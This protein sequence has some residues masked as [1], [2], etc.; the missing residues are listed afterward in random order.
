MKY[1]LFL[2]VLFFAVAV[3]SAQDFSGYRAGNFTGVNG[4]FFNPASIADSRYR[5]DLNLISAS[6]SVGNNKASFNL[7]DVIKSF[8]ADSLKQQVTGRNA[9]PSNGLISV[10]IH[11]PSF[12]FNAG[13]KMAFA[14]TSR[15]RA[16][17]NITD[18]DGKLADKLMTDFDNNDPALPYTIASNNNMRVNVHAWSEF[19][20]TVARVIKDNGPHFFKTGITF[21]YLAGAGNAYVNAA[22]IRGTLNENRAGDPYLINASGRLSLGFG[23]INLSDDVE[24]SELTKMVTTGFGA[25]IGFVYEY[26]PAREN[27]KVGE[28]DMLRRDANK[29]KFKVG[30]ALLDIGSLKYKRDVQRSGSYTVDVSGADTLQLREL[31]DVELNDY[32]AF[33][34]SRPQYFTP[35]NHNNAGTYNVALPATL[36]INIDYHLHRGFYIDLATQ[37][38]LSKSDSK[39]YNSNYYSGVTLTPRYEGRKI[40]LYV[41]VNYNGLTKFNAGAS[42]R[43]GAF[44]VGSGS[45]LTAVL[46]NSKQADAYV[47]LRLF[48]IMQKKN[49]KVL[50]KMEKKARKTEKRAAKDAATE[51]A[52]MEQ[53]QPKAPEQ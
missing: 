32:K 5:F 30:V 49:S 13:R 3:V 18:L 22:G 2:F 27:Y 11:G 7:K 42:L 39:P 29:Y 44:F 41:P 43:L 24:V 46:G 26:R 48:G 12:M 38:A 52:K 6:T 14:L 45:V 47:G 19:G 31:E 16:M 15:V 21:K 20:L 51:A 4:A 53:S 1:Y 28:T 25:D 8:D 23:G 50:H 17:T 35:D 10:D 33:F 36:H 37:L 40:G 34:D 9:G